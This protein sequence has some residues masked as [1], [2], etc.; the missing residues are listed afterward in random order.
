[1]N[2]ELDRLTSL[3]Y[4][5]IDQ[6][7]CESELEIDNQGKYAS[8][9]LSIRSQEKI[10]EFHQILGDHN[11]EQIKIFEEI[12]YSV[13]EDIEKYKKEAIRLEK[14][15]K[16]ERD[17]NQDT[18]K[19]MIDEAERQMNAISEKIKNQ[20]EI[21]F[22]KVIEALKEEYCQEISYL[23]ESLAKVQ[24][25]EKKLKKTK[26]DETSQVNELR[27][28]IENLTI[29][30]RDLKTQLRESQSEI[31]ILRS[32]IA[33]LA[34]I[35]NEKNS[36]NYLPNETLVELCR[37]KQE[38]AALQN[39]N[40]KLN[41]TNDILRSTIQSARQK[42]IENKRKLSS[43][44]SPQKD[45]KL[46]LRH[47]NALVKHNST[48]SS[49]F[50]Q[51]EE[52]DSGYLPSSN[53]ISDFNSDSSPFFPVYL[54]NNF[55]YEC[56]STPVS[57][58][59]DQNKF[60]ENLPENENR[61]STLAKPTS[62]NVNTKS[63][64]VNNNKIKQNV[65]T[66]PERVFKVVFAGDSGVGKTSFIMRYCKGEF[67]SSTSS[68][69]GVDHYMK[70]MD[71][72]GK[73]VALQLW[74]TCGQERFRSIAKSYFRRADG[75]V[76]MYDCTYEKSFLNVRE[77]VEII[78][79]T[80]DKRIPIVIIGNKIDLREEIGQRGRVVQKEDGVKLAKQYNSF[81]IETSAKDGSNI[82]ES[83]IEICRIMST[84]QDIEL[85]SDRI[86]LGQNLQ[87]KKR[88]CC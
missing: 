40:K 14:S 49:S 4:N 70:T 80:S 13:L 36:E 84:N 27:T 25:N 88:N 39:A 73:R 87:A 78:N 8:I 45:E 58:S 50:D 22:M 52:L 18:I 28:E 16:N 57:D 74:D 64:N 65:N 1:M 38:I 9:G 55:K 41:D 62:L 11:P 79:E 5:S 23:Q 24:E 6:Y 81:F 59:L 56:Q 63:I 82:D 48:F 37:L 43:P 29:E 60:N 75:V 86:R 19:N 42:E 46:N 10:C 68:T 71:I 83:L 33:E 67:N 34:N 21:R 54:N 7:D 66:D 44:F 17:Q 20:E 72:D 31:S 51:D 2:W 12:L 76:L 53:E 3:E 30:N 69:I 32:E 35:C 77:W 47:I 61:T 15:Y 85:K 26:Q